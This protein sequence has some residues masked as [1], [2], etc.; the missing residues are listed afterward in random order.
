MPE[1]DL[2][3]FK[4][5]TENGPHT[6]HLVKAI[7]EKALSVGEDV[8]KIREA[9]RTV[10][11]AQDQLSVAYKALSDMFRNTTVENPTINEP[12]D[13]FKQFSFQFCSFMDE[14]T[15]I[16]HQFARD[17]QTCLVTQLDGYLSTFKELPKESI[18]L[19]Q[20]NKI[21]DQA[22]QSYMKLSKKCSYK[23]IHSALS[24][25]ATARCDFER[26]ACI[27][28][29]HLNEAGYLREIAPLL[30]VSVLL[31]TQ[32]QHVNALNQVFGE[33]L[34]TY[35]TAAQS[36]LRRRI[37]TQESNALEF[38]SHV[39]NLEFEPLSKFCPEPHLL[40]SH[41]D[42][43]TQY[44]VPKTHLQSKSGRLLMRSRTAL[45]SRWIEVFC[46]TQ[47]GNLMSQ[48][49][50]EIGASLLIDL[51]QK[52]VYAETTECEERR[53]VFQIISPTEHKCII[54]QAESESEK[55]EWIH[56]LTNVIFHVNRPSQLGGTINASNAGSHGDSGNLLSPS[57]PAN[58]KASDQLSGDSPADWS[59]S[60][61]P[62]VRFDLSPLPELNGARDAEL[63]R[64]HRTQLAPDAKPVVD[65]NT[66]SGSA[67]AN[68][69]LILVPEELPEPIE[70]A[71]LGA[72][73]L[74]DSFESVDPVKLN[75]LFSY[76]LS[77]RSVS[78][79]PEPLVCALLITQCDVWLV[80]RTLSKGGD[81]VISNHGDVLVRVPFKQLTS[82]LIYP[83]NPRLVCLV[84]QSPLKETSA[85]SDIHSRVCFAFESDDNQ[86]LAE[87]L[88][89]AQLER[90]DMLQDEDD[91]VERE[92]L[93]SN[94]ARL[95]EAATSNAAG[96]H[97]L[98]H[99]STVHSASPDQFAQDASKK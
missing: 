38:R 36:G 90:I 64:P 79:S 1:V 48:Q 5:V 22:F 32:T 73:E 63:L 50:D 76:I 10:C 14:L 24:E 57:V 89:A 66:P 52:G 16:H 27:Y 91:T 53:N 6:K 97:S 47:S 78:A 3:N 9:V 74:P 28:Y 12:D 69:D 72:V 30:T 77:C 33:T 70:I 98:H 51:N 15:E 40:D 4:D 58:V 41:L 26:K 34:A 21:C 96:N 56:A 92:L 87:R 59:A 45:L 80:A 94:I 54:L 75:D 8:R 65:E 46:F 39:N 44:P 35:L 99:S 49:C 67:P 25:L 18:G 83:E 19:E 62:P 60:C 71:F 2:L 20:S 61:L 86:L 17:L 95:S 42:T 88:L 84:V 85:F 43:P 82:C 31:D 37:E 7:F 55:D 29:G 68:S 11:Q 23:V 81:V 13:E 93:L